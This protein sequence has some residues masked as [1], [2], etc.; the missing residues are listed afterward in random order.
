MASFAERMLKLAADDKT[1]KKA[2][3]TKGRTAVV[4]EQSKSGPDS[5]SS[6]RGHVSSSPAGAQVSP[7]VARE[8]PQKRPREE[9]STI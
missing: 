7:S 8:P 5:S 6:P 1:T 2:K 3:K 4:L 9:D